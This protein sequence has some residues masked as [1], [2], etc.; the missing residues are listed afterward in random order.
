MIFFFCLFLYF[1]LSIYI[2]YIKLVIYI[3]IYQVIYLYF[4]LWSYL[5]TSISIYQANYLYFYLSS[6]LFI[7]LSIKLHIYLYSMFLSI[8]IQSN[9]KLQVNTYYIYYMSTKNKLNLIYRNHMFHSYSILNPIFPA[10]STFP[11]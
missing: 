2:F 7:F 3:S 11:F 6:Y 5:Y 10:P 1:K 4:Y 9:C 8:P